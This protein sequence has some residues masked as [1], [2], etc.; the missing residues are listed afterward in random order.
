MSANGYG[1]MTVSHLWI[2]NCWGLGT[3]NP[4]HC[5]RLNCTWKGFELDPSAI[6]LMLKTISLELKP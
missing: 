3:F 2:F 6:I 4:Q 5:S 1:G